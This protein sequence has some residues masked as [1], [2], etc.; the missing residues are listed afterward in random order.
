MKLVAIQF[1]QPGGF[2]V[3]EYEVL[4]HHRELEFHIGRTSWADWDHRGRL[5]FTRDGKLFAGKFTA[6]GAFQSKELADF[7]GVKPIRIESPTWA[8]KW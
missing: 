4:T 2:Y 6:K 7:N 1:R 5:V 8:K 3:Y